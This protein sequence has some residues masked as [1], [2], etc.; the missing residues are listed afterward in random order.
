VIKTPWYRLGLVWAS[1][2][3]SACA[4]LPPPTLPVTVTVGTSGGPNAVQAFR[5]AQSVSVRVLPSETPAPDN[6][7]ARARDA[8]KQLPL[9]VVPDVTPPTADVIATLEFLTEVSKPETIV[10]RITQSGIWFG[11]GGSG[12][13]LTFDLSGPRVL[14]RAIR[15]RFVAANDATIQ[16]E[17]TARVD[18][19]RTWNERALRAVLMASLKDFPAPPVNQRVIQQPL[20]DRP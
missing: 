18:A 20:T 8:L 5:D 9:T 2:A 13:N 1:F 10:D 12:F 14:S 15:W 7:E 17:I 3:L 6:L 16:Q 4:S 11:T 19:S